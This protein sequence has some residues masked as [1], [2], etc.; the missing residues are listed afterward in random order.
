MAGDAGAAGPA[1]HPGAAGRATDAAAQPGTG[2]AARP[3]RNPARDRRLQ[4]GL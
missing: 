1:R 2:S 3:A 4:T